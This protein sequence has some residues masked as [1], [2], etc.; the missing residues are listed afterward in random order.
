MKIPQCQL[1]DYIVMFE[2]PLKMSAQLLRHGGVKCARKDQRGYIV[3]FE[4]PLKMAAQLLRHGG[5]KCARKDQRG[6]PRA[7]ENG[8]VHGDHKRTE[9][10]QARENRH[11]DNTVT[12]PG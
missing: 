7:D 11:A 4:T 3:M 9:Q 5:V 6:K 2:T 8:T 1:P 12:G 10:R